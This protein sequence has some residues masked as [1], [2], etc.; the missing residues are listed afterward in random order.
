MDLSRFKKKFNIYLFD[1]DHSEQSQYMAI[2]YYLPAL[3]DTFILIVDDWNWPDVR[4][5][6]MRGIAESKLSVLWKKEIRLTDNDQH[7]P[8]EEASKTFWNGIAAF[9]LKK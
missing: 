7:T 5:G 8:D 3:E 4:N 1:G 6:T 9:V 2:K